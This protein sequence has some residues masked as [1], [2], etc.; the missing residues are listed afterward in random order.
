MRNTMRAALLATVAS[1]TATAALGADR[2]VHVFLSVAISPDGKHVASIEGDAT[3]SGAVDIKSVVIRGTDGSEGAPGTVTR[4]PLPCG[5]VRECAPS[6]L[7]W[8]PDGAKLAFALRLPGGHNH[9]IYT[10]PAAGG[11]PAR[12]ASV[13]GTIGRLRYSPAGV[14]AA[15]ATAGAEKEVGA[16]E[17]GAP[18]AGVL[19]GDVHEQRIAI[20]GQDGKLSWAS[21]PD[22]SVY[23]YDW[24]PDGSGF[25]GTAAH[26]DGDNNWW[27]AKL[28]AFDA[29]SGEG[30][31]IYAP[32]NP[33]QQLADPRISH[34]GKNVSFIGG[35][36]SDF[37]STG[38]DAFVLPLDDANAQA[39]DI[40]RGLHATITALAWD[41][42]GK[43][44]LA[45]ELAADQ[46]KLVTL[47]PRG[48]A[49]GK[50][51]ASSQEDLRGTDDP[52]SFACGTQQT[53]ISHVSFSKPPEIET[54][55]PGAW[56]D[57]TRANAG[58][59]AAVTAT[60]V[61][62]NNEGLSVQGWL[63]T[64][65][66]GGQAGES[67]KK[68]AMITE[69]HGG[70]G[71]ANEP[72]Y[73][74]AGFS[75]RLLDAGYALFLP[76]PR[77]SFGQGEAFTLGNVRDLGHG[78]L[79]DI[80]A[81]ITEAERVAPV[82]E[83]R[84]GLTGWSYGG[85]MTMWSVTQTNRFRAAVAGAGIAN[86]QS[87]YGENGIDAWMIPFFGASVY[88]DPA[89]YAKSSPINFIKN[90]KTPTLEVVGERDIECP[91]PQTQEF[92]HAL[93]DLGVPTVGVI[94]PGE[95]HGMRDPKHIE[96][97]ENRMVAWFDKYLK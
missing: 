86:W 1:G 52:V 94:Y 47:D 89:I 67:G 58:L 19:G 82:D 23:E 22:L 51:L 9:D 45:S 5:A 70:P 24:R 85:F 77:G 41:C 27:V 38:G 3:P 12:I 90:V 71:A 87:Y 46:R 36:M 62:W 31:V 68:I 26:G 92:W 81:G 69:V 30:R 55:S 60:N 59:T 76:N 80:L 79:R 54:G 14:L 50:T 32:A 28:Y 57:L 97:F 44:L 2:P 53:A 95:G 40:T 21:P 10:V 6:S 73:A 34:D 65:A 13:N 91:A 48:A 4:V 49:P 37:G 63:L 35:I 75:R 39:T 18:V 15:L 96:D 83:H 17:A 88:D 16:V 43:S 93:D 20:I 64:P 7:A 78:D 84:L 11:T 56:H 29:H 72:F 33:R 42:D 61:T 25:V 66:S 8:T 74:G